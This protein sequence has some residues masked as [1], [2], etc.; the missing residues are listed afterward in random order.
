MQTRACHEP[1]TI[2][3]VPYRASRHAMMAGNIA[4]TSSTIFG[5]N[6]SCALLQDQVG[7]SRARC[8][9]GRLPFCTAWMQPT[10][11]PCTSFACSTACSLARLHPSRARLRRKLGERLHGLSLPQSDNT[12]YAESLYSLALLQGDN[13][14]YVALAAFQEQEPLLHACTCTQ[15][16]NGC[17][18]G[19]TIA[20][21]LT[22]SVLE[23]LK[24]GACSRHCTQCATC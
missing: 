14:H 16:K 1:E 7:Q 24:V 6:L 5:S 11:R 20:A 4:T 19:A 9:F 17:T 3:Q 21:S 2:E 13:L 22:A 12:Q 23:D 18:C 8:S 10:G 15:P